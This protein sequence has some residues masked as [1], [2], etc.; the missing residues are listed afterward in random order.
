MTLQTAVEEDKEALRK[1]E[2]F[3]ELLKRADDVLDRTSR[4]TEM[5]QARTARIAAE[6]KE[7][8]EKEKQEIARKKRER[9]IR[10]AP[11]PPSIPSFRPPGP[12]N[13]PSWN[14]S[15]KLEPPTPS[16]VAKGWEY[17]LKAGES[18]RRCFEGRLLKLRS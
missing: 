12:K 3:R 9:R 13:K 10:R 2:A 14:V 16:P 7:Q 18:Q 1:E 15:R 6:K 11:P 5:N 8:K 17:G 4:F